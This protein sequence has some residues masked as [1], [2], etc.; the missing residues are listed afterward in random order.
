M[1][2]QRCNSGRIMSITAHAKDLHTVQFEDYEYDGYLP[3]DLGVGGGDDTTID[4]CL[5]C[6]QLQGQWPL[7]ETGMETGRPHAKDQ[8]EDEGID[9]PASGVIVVCNDD[10]EVFK[11]DREKRSDVAY[12]EHGKLTI[13]KVDE[14]S[15]Y[16]ARGFYIDKGVK[17]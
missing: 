16:K 17:Q 1:K 8:N 9:L 7:E 11:F 4:Y 15:T 6:G 12:F 14:V 5:N 13:I 3:S 10:K 2:C